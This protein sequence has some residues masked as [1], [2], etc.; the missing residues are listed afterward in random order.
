MFATARPGQS[1]LVSLEKGK[2]GLAAI[3][4]EAVV[5]GKGRPE[6]GRRSGATRRTSE[7]ARGNVRSKSRAGAC[8][9]EPAYSDKKNI[10]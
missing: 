4:R 3:L 1:G 5:R 6:A 7:S 8:N 10:P 2:D 9:W